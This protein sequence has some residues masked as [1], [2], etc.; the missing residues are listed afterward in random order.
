M[1]A[2]E[3]RP[4]TPEQVQASRMD[5]M[6]RYIR[7][8]VGKPLGVSLAVAEKYQIFPLASRL[9]K[10]YS[11]M[12][13]QVSSRSRAESQSPAFNQVLS[14]DATQSLTQLDETT[15]DFRG[16]DPSSQP[17]AIRLSQVSQN[18][19]DTSRAMDK[20]SPSY[21]SQDQSPKFL[22]PSQPSTELSIHP[23]DQSGL[24]P[25]PLK[26]EPSNSGAKSAA[27]GAAVAAAAQFA[28][29]SHGMDPARGHSSPLHSTPRASVSSGIARRRTRLPQ[30]SN[31]N[32]QDPS[33]SIASS[34][35]PPDSP[36][37]P[38]VF[39]SSRPRG[40]SLPR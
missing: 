29:L 9:Y 26:D 30:G 33:H 40:P 11:G 22:Q 32:P 38:T 27:R 13:R 28:I 24:P 4:L 18:S 10:A 12:R 20:T 15:V 6:M 7:D 21:P 37:S 2:L 17:H 25:A 23:N 14:Q 8:S 36:A 1:Y 3:I 19:V 31:P 34:T 35:R 5:K 39:P 16:L